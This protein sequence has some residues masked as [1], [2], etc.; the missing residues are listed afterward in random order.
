MHHWKLASVSCQ[1]CSENFHSGSNKNT[2]KGS[3]QSANCQR[4]CKNRT[5]NLIQHITP[6]GR[7]GLNVQ[8]VLASGKTHSSSLP[9]ACSENRP[10]CSDSSVVATF[11][12]RCMKQ[13][14]QLTGERRSLHNTDRSVHCIPVDT[15][16]IA[17]F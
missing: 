12:P 16:E 4:R 2:P 15:P 6:F 5:R 11:N 17:L 13:H 7:K 14:Q 9:S 3:L 10:S 8:H 1:A